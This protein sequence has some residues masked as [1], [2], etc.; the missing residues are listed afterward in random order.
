MNVATS[1]KLEKAVQ[2]VATLKKTVDIL[3]ATVK[4]LEGRIAELEGAKRGN[5]HRQAPSSD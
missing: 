1:Q 5:R 2:E 4:A 3:A